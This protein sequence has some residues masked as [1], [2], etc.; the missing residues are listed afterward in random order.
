MQSNGIQENID[1][2]AERGRLKILT[3]AAIACSKLTTVMPSS[4]NAC[5]FVLVVLVRK[6]GAVVN[7]R[8]WLE[9]WPFASSVP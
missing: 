3:G 2:T 9:V 6:G 4:G 8:W 1:T 5:A 7:N